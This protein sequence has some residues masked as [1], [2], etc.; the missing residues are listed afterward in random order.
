MSAFECFDVFFAQLS[1]RHSAAVVHQFAFVTY[2]LGPD[3]FFFLFGKMSQHFF[4]EKEQDGEKMGASRGPCAAFFFSFRPLLHPPP[5]TR[6]CLMDSFISRRFPL[7]SAHFLKS[8][9]PQLNGVQDGC[10]LCS[11]LFSAPLS[12]HSFLPLVFLIFFCPMKAITH[13]PSTPP[14]SF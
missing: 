8:T 3:F 12:S 11:Q 9:S 10:E 2:L 13:F 6:R 7:R 4:A 14:S 1:C 5:S